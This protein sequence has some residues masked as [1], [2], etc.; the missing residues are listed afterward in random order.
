MNITFSRSSYPGQVD[1][2]TVDLSEVDED[3]FVVYTTPDNKFPLPGYFRVLQEWQESTHP[4]ISW[5]SSNPLRAGTYHVE[6]LEHKFP[7]TGASSPVLG[8][9]K[10]SFKL[11]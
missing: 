11:E 1:I 10:F 3:V 4:Q 2:F 6:I 7:I 8:P 5:T 9:T